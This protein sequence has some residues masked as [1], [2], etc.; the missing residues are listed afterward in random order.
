M[1]LPQQ[2]RAERERQISG[3]GWTPEHDDHHDDGEMLIVAGIYYRSAIGQ[4][5]PMRDAWLRGDRRSVPIGWPW[6]AHD[7]K[8][9]T[10]ARD[11]ERAGALCL[12]EIDRLKRKGRP[13][14][15]VEETLSL[16]VSAYRARGG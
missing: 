13:V 5:L 11:L 10:P 7:W 1:E 9:K 3:E 2:I 15:H 14:A 4:T 16:I 12:A 6:E 8:P